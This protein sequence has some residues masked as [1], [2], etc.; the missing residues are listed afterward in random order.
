MMHCICSVEFYFSTILLLSFRLRERIQ[1]FKIKTRLFSV[2]CHFSYKCLFVI[3]VF[4]SLSERTIFDFTAEQKFLFFFFF[5]IRF[6]ALVIDLTHT[7]SFITENESSITY[8]NQI[9]SKRNE[10]FFPC[11]CFFLCL[12][13][14]IH[15]N[16]S[17]RSKTLCFE[18]KWKVR[19]IKIE[20]DR[21]R[22]ND[23]R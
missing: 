12:F 8:K 15:R 2:I 6:I 13:L 3:F 7:K 14:Q 10:H 22:E 23:R 1:S 21:Q 5:F 20:R 4:F 16:L 19:A 11:L 17:F 18:S 9:N